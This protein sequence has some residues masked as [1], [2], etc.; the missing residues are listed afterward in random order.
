MRLPSVLFSSAVLAALCSMLMGGCGEGVQEEGPG[1]ALNG[2]ALSADFP[3]NAADKVTICHVPPGNPANAHTIVVGASG[4]NGHSKHKGD[5]M[6]PCNGGGTPDA[7]T[8][9]PPPTDGGTD[10]QPTPDA[11]TPGPTCEPQGAACGERTECC[12]GLECSNGT[13]QPVIG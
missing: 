7:G 5:Y 11:G 2:E 1:P 3:A 13:C 4:W 10:P 9:P 6:G 8:P 12:N